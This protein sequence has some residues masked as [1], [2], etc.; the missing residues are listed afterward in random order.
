MISI[1]ITLGECWLILFSVYCAGIGSTFYFLAFR[2][3]RKR[4]INHGVIKFK[5]GQAKSA[6]YSNGIIYVRFDRS[7]IFKKNDIVI[8]SNG[9]QFIVV[10]PKYKDPWWKKALRFCGFKITNYNNY[11]KLKPL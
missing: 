1:V 8:I 4:R 6:L 5:P 2:N 11:T 3:K 10:N 7:N 9:Q